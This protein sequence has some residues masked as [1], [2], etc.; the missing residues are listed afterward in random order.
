MPSVSVPR[1]FQSGDIQLASLVQER[2]EIDHLV[3]I[4]EL[5]PK[6]I[7][8]DELPVYLVR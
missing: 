6:F 7:A 2:L 4:V 5:G 8:K 3:P 1:S